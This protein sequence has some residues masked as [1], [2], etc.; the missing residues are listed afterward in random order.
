MLP[1]DDPLTWLRALCGS[2]PEVEETVAWGH[3]NFRT[4]GRTFAVFE[5]YRGRP[6]IAV[7]AELA[8][9]EILVEQFGFFRTPYA[10]MQGWV[11]A[12]V[13]EAAPWDLLQDLITK[14]YTATKR[15]PRRKASAPSASRRRSQ[16]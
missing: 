3:P 15:A 8:D 5:V 7:K 14:A 13:D 11:S 4:A 9:Q 1:L 16:T 2:L 12:W 10:G 6:S